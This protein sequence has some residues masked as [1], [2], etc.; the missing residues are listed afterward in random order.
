L[1]LPLMLVLATFVKKLAWEVVAS[2]FG[3]HWNT[4]KTTVKYVVD[5]GL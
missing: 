2:L 3:L 4:V 5:Y 1:T